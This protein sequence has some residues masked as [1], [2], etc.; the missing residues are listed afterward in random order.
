[1]VEIKN[2]KQK[3]PDKLNIF[4]NKYFKVITLLVTVVV[5]IAGYF[6]FLQSRINEL[7]ETAKSLLPAKKA[8]LEALNSYQEEISNLESII[9]NFQARYAEK[10]ND[11][12]QILPTKAQF[13]ELIAQIDALVQ[14]SGFSL[15]AIEI[16][17]SEIKSEK[18]VDVDEEGGKVLSL[19]KEL[20][21]VEIILEVSGGEYP[22]F[23]VLLDKIERH[24]RFL[25]VVSITFTSSQETGVYALSLRTYYFES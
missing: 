14:K 2:K 21:L 6:F 1:M 8:E 10:I 13:P 18:E 24:V 20:R 25:D 15:N 12:E 5:F 17:E 22:A 7:R 16:S 23:K 9:E 4:L 19:E 11:L 3:K